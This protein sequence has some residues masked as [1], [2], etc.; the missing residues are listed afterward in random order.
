MLKHIES[1]ISGRG[2]GPNSLRHIKEL[3]SQLQ[4]R[5]VAFTKPD[6]SIRVAADGEER[7]LEEFVK[8]LERVN[9]FSSIENF[10]VKWQ[11]PNEESKNFYVLAN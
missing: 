4:I 3:A 2:L 7:N 5:G 6:G 10:Y 11:E 8:K 1:G 9:I